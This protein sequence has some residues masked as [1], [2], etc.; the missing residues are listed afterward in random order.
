MKKLPLIILVVNIIV[1]IPNITIAQQLNTSQTARIS[2]FTKI[3][4]FLKYY[5]PEISKGFIDWDS[6]YLNFLP[7]VEHADN[8]SYHNIIIEIIESLDS[9]HFCPTCENF[10]RYP[11]EWTR[12]LT[13]NWIEED[14]LLSDS[15][16]EKLKYIL[17][18]RHQGE[19]HYV[20]Y[21]WGEHARGGQIKFINEKDYNDSLLINDSRYRL[22][23]L[24]RYWNAIEYF[25]A[26][27]YLLS[28][29]WNSELHKYIP[30]FLRENTLEEYHL[31]VTRLTR[32][33]ED[34][35]SGSGHSRYLLKNRWNYKPPFDIVT[36]NDMT[37]VRGIRFTE[38]NQV[39]DIQQGDEILEVDGVPI[40]KARQVMYDLCKGSNGAVTNGAI[41]AQLLFGNTEEFNLL[42]RRE[43]KIHNVEV[44]RY[45]YKDYWEYKQKPKP[46]MQIEENHAIIDF[47]LLNSKAQIDSLLDIAKEKQVLILDIR[48]YPM[49][50]FKD[51]EA[52]FVTKSNYGFRAFEPSLIDVG[53]FKPSIL[54]K[55]ELDKR[56]HYKG[57]IVVMVNEYT[58][59]YG[60]S[61]AMFFQS[62]PNS[63]VVG[64]QTSGANGN[65]TRILL[66]GNFNASF[67][68]LIIEYPDGSQSQKT[69]IQIDH[70]IELTAEDIINDN[71]PYLELAKSLAK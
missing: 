47:E 41:D 62:L 60:E 17:E 55:I 64:S 45:P 53:I 48:A 8:E 29:D 37:L 11:E 15:I 28:E 57:K 46:A 27:K 31:N 65:T 18:N 43:G 36:I 10:Q 34:S 69:G 6:I 26:Y 56:N 66:P 1:S 22:L 24:A 50:D 61:C 12:N 14:T 25:F 4:G 71:D 59:S 67:T 16:K 39:N 63:T 44:K 70:Y 38:L 3:W 9:V 51:M 33:I 23:T 20:A 35:H 54:T 21:A 49:F 42:I 2:N 32:E 5:H 68:N 19:G 30:I 52:H 40:K 58:Q 7:E 13:I